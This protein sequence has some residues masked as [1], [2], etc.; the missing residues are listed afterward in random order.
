M[1]DEQWN[2]DHARTVTMFLNGDAITEPDRRGQRIVDDSFL[3]LFN[4]HH[5][6]LPSPH[7]MPDTARNG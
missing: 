2:V 4:A 5:E 6:P 7:R 3:V 1:S